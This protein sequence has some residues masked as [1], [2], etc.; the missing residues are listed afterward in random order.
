MCEATDTSTGLLVRV[1][2]Y[3]RL[4]GAEVLAQNGIAGVADDHSMPIGISEP[5]EVRFIVHREQFSM[6][7]APGADPRLPECPFK[8][9]LGG[10]VAGDRAYLHS[11]LLHRLL[12]VPTPSHDLLHG[13]VEIILHRWDAREGFLTWML[14]EA[15]SRMGTTR[16]EVLLWDRS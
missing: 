13:Y 8:E 4:W 14:R 11:G 6:N 10:A 9:V 12:A 1:H 3:G 2:F 7:T 15:R 5:N 16:P